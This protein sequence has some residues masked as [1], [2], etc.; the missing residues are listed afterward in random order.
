M[1]LSSFKFS[2]F[3]KNKFQ[4]QVEEILVRR[5]PRQIDHDQTLLRPSAAGAALGPEKIREGQ[6]PQSQTTDLQKG[7]PGL[8]VAKGLGIRVAVNGQHREPL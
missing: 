2:S 8:P 5:P 1:F 4:L 3:P 7:A 6:S